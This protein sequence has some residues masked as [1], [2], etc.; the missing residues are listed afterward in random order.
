MKSLV[1]LPIRKMLV[2]LGVA[3]LTALPVFAQQGKRKIDTEHSTAS[4]FLGNSSDLQ[5][6]GITR[7][8]GNAEFNSAEPAKSALDIS[9]ELPQGRL[10][11][12]KSKR[13]DLRPD[14]KLQI[15]GEMTLAGTERGATYTAAEDYSGPVYGEPV[16]RTITREVAFVVPLADS[17]GRTGEITAEAILGVENFPELF[18]AVRQASWQPVVQDEACEVSQTGEDYRGAICTGTVMAPVSRVTAIRIGE[19]YRGLES[20]MPSG[21]LMKIVLRLGLSRVDLG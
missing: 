18:A 11:A 2:I 5:N 10:M 19:D 3:S 6:V 14:G 7:V 20:T 9:A 4:I 21:N 12:F 8:G 16:V 15:T 17:A 1:T 13:I